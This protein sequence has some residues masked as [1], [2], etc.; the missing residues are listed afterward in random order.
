MTNMWLFTN[1]LETGISKVIGDAIEVEKK[2]RSTF[3]YYENKNNPTNPFHV[4][5]VANDHNL[6]YAQQFFGK[7]RVWSLLLF[8]PTHGTLFPSS[9][10]HTGL[11]RAQFM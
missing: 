11:G 6:A 8:Y 4:I 9:D 2:E 3:R 7:V 5:G 10:H 1:G